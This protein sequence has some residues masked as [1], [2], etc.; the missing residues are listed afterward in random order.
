MDT[1]TPEVIPP[2]E[3]SAWE[4]IPDGEYAIVEL[5]GHTTLVGRIEE[6]ERFGTKML[7]IQPLFSGRL[8]DPI[9]HGGAAI[10]RLS[11]CSR[12]TA[13][14]RQPKESWQLPAAI[15]AV[16]PVDLLPAPSSPATSASCHDGDDDDCVD[17]GRPF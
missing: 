16:M 1:I 15:R 6:V 5:F 2:A 7:A 10:Y 3:P 9:Y 12:E 14:K 8:L 11:P 4:A 17:D 13:W